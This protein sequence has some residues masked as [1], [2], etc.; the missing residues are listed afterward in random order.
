MHVPARPYVLIVSAN[1]VCP[2]ASA[3]SVPKTHQIR[4][5]HHIAKTFVHKLM[6]ARCHPYAMP[7]RYLAIQHHGVVMWQ[8]LSRAVHSHA[9]RHLGRPLD[10][11]HRFNAPNTH[12]A[13]GHSSAFQ[14]EHGLR[15]KQARRRAGRAKYLASGDGRPLHLLHD[16]AVGL[17]LMTC[18]CRPRPPTL[19]VSTSLPT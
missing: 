19:P 7:H 14:L 16:C 10:P 1:F 3:V 18:I 9:T 6:H 5:L 15:Y 11:A 8:P 2:Q 4:C 17:G 12:P 13:R